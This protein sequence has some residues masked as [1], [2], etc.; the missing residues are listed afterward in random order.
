M[1][2][3]ESPVVF[4]SMSETTMQPTK[5][6][7]VY[8]YSSELVLQSQY[9]D[10][11]RYSIAFYDGK[12]NI[13]SVEISGN[14]VCQIDMSFYGSWK[15]NKSTATQRK[16]IKLDVAM[17]YYGKERLNADGLMYVSLVGRE[18]LLDDLTNGLA[19][20]KIQLKLSINIDALEKLIARRNDNPTRFG[21]GYGKAKGLLTWYADPEIQKQSLGW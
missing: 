6:Y 2:V 3:F 5:A 19:H 14:T 1:I 12:R 11:V 4:K 17:Q 16:L 20:A 18:I 21:E 9:G 8:H 15:V 10:P 7:I 13:G